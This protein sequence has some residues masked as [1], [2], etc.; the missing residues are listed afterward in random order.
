MP[1]PECLGNCLAAAVSSEL[2]SMNQSPL[3]DVVQ[4]ASDSVAVLPAAKPSLDDNMRSLIAGLHPEEPQRERR[5]ERRYPYPCLLRLAAFESEG[6]SGEPIEEL[7]ADGITVVG[8]Q[9]SLGGIG[10]YHQEP[11]ADRLVVIEFPEGS[12]SGDTPLR[13]LVDLTWCRFARQG[14]YESGG[15][16]VREV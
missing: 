6:N 15:R 13:V 8:H 10:F 7:F 14:W 11:L 16:L 12:S 9:V 5:R 4:A 1:T 3:R 2:E